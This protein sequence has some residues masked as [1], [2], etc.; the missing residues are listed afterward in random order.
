MRFDLALESSGP[1]VCL[2]TLLLE[3]H[4]GTL[5]PRNHRKSCH[6]LSGALS[7]GI[8]ELTDLERGTS[9]RCCTQYRTH[10]HA[11]RLWLGSST[12]IL[13]TRH[14]VRI[15]SSAQRQQ[16]YYRNSHVFQGNVRCSNL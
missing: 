8:A 12:Q 6:D 2:V 16:A 10:S 13:K 3:V 5:R 7:G 1:R 4:R 14:H 9:F 11:E 15:P